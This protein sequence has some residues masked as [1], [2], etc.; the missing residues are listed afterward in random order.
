MLLSV[1]VPDRIARCLQ[2]DGPTAQRRALEMFAL[3]GY[4]EGSL[5]RGQV[6]E[7]LGMG[8]QETDEFLK[9]HN[10]PLGLTIADYERSN[11][12]LEQLLS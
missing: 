9:R 6:S 5:S 4:R 11:A 2:L 1:E 8:F 12:A 10:A 7:M 3:A